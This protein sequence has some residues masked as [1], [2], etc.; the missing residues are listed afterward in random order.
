L[1]SAPPPRLRQ[2]IDALQRFDRRRVAALIAE[3]LR[4]GPPS[5]DHWGNVEAVAIR[6]GE[7]NFGLEAARRYALTEPRTLD[8]TLHYCNALAARGRIDACLHETDRLPIAVQQHPAVLYLRGTIAARL[9]DFAQAAELAQRTIALAPQFGHYWHALA[10]A[11]KFAPGDP[12]LARMEAWASEMRRTPADSQS[13][14]FYALGKARHD[15]GDYDGAFAAWSEAA[16]KLRAPFDAAAMEHFVRDVIRDFTPENFERLTPSGCDSDRVIFVIGLPRSGTTLVEQILASHSAVGDGEEVNLFC[17]ALIPAGDFSL[18]GGL[19][20]QART[21][22]ADPWGEIGRDYL[23]MLQQRFGSDG[24][25]VDKTLNHS[26]FLG[27]ILHSLP[28]ARVIWMR[29]NAEDTAISCFRTW[30][31]TGTIPWSCSLAD[32]GWHFRLEDALHAHWTQIYP[33]RILTV[34]YEELA[35]DPQPWI[36]RILAHVG[37]DPESAAFTPHLKKRAVQTASVAQV[38]EPIT[39]SSVGVAEKYRAHLQPFREAYKTP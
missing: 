16:A 39:A 37:L 9:G 1:Q 14:F 24:R 3:E 4:E 30:F 12:A 25:I 15:S 2:V 22:G 33:D 34:P 21:A 35:R 8:R 17:T 7:I 11:K 38:R 27:F 13:A 6:I 28:N 29:R 31:G 32:I 5:G 18:Q 36:T 20:Y 26:R 23:A 10:M 19:D